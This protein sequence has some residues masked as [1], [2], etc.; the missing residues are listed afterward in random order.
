MPTSVDVWEDV[1]PSSS[2][3]LLPA[4]RDILEINSKIDRDIVDDRGYYS[5]TKDQ[6]T[7]LVQLEVV[8]PA[9][10]RAESWLA[11]PIWR[12]DTKKHG[13]V[14]RLFG[15]DAKFKYVWPTGL[16]L[17]FDVHPECWDLLDDTNIP[18]MFTEGIKKADAI[19]SAARREG[20]PLVV[21]AVN[22]CDGWKA[23]VAGSSIASPDFLDIPWEDRRV[24]VNSDSDYRT[25]N[26]VSSG[27]NGCAT[28]VSS[29]TG[30]HRTFL[31]V[32]PPHGTEKQGA[33]DFL[34]RGRTLGDLLEVAQSPERAILDDSGQRPPLKIKNGRQLIV[35]AGDKIPHLLTPIIPDRSIVLVAG[36]SGTFK[37]WNLLGLALDSSFGLPW[38]GHPDLKVEEGSLTSLYV[39][40]EMAGLILGQRLKT[41]ARNERYTVLADYDETIQNRLLFS[42]E[43]DLDMNREDQR[44]RLEDAIISTGSRVVILDSLSMSWHGDENSAS[45]VGDF[46]SALRGIIER[47]GC[48]FILLHHLLKPPGGKPLKQDNISQFSIRGSGQLYQQ[49]DACL[50]MCLYS[51]GSSLQ[52]DD[53]K[54]VAVH[55]IKART[56]VELPSWVI[57]FETHDGP[58]TSLTYLCKLSEAKARDYAESGGDVSKL[59]A[60]I[61][62]ECLAMPAMLPGPGNPGFRFKHLATLLQQAWNIPDKQAPSDSTLR[63]QFEEMVKSGRL[64]LLEESKRHG[65]LYRLAEDSEPDPGEKIESEEPLAPTIPT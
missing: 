42:H 62:E 5:L 3:M 26:R 13:E 14:I 51:T 31:V 52:A 30:E 24:Y 12:P 37:T 22:G 1:A 59:K 49:A 2:R 57:K 32:T 58:F 53:E 7:K 63:R 41:L 40:K 61:L 10:M 54:L 46:Y 4:H 21:V 33:D 48:T 56:S 39:N 6:I 36:H 65:N 64:V 11:L 45:E 44:D 27:W 55:H 38:F 20:T 8:A 60:W 16:R 23:K 43:P 18:V 17:A 50:L 35:E 47:T 15:G 34:V 29:K 9:T 28:Y 25:N 19:L